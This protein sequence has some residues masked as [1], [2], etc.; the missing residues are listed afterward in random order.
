[1]LSGP[2]TV[3]KW[4]W[5]P[6]LGTKSLVPN[7][8][9]SILSVLPKTVN[10]K[11]FNKKVYD[12]Y[13]K[14]S[15]QATLYLKIKL[16]FWSKAYLS[17]LNIK[18]NMKE[19]SVCNSFWCISYCCPNS[20]S[21]LGPDFKSLLTHPKNEVLVHKNLSVEH[22][23]TLC[24]NHFHVPNFILMSPPVQACYNITSKE[25]YFKSACYLKYPWKWLTNNVF[26]IPNLINLQLLIFMTLWMWK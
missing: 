3:Q 18:Q 2:N 21:L 5:L 4:Q 23:C 13:S 25:T 10:N 24:K 26:E 8:T 1:M 12:S 6:L 16:T 19:L 15:T 20:N 22:W 7:S 17:R 14:V 11:I 9:F